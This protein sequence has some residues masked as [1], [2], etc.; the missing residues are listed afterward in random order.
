MD[1]CW[2]P[3]VRNNIF[4]HILKPHNRTSFSVGSFFLSYLAKSSFT[5]SSHFYFSK[6]SDEMPLISTKCVGEWT[7]GFGKE[8]VLKRS[9]LAI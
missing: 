2:T 7:R 3:S 5:S 8:A 1:V 4:M 6:P 9:K